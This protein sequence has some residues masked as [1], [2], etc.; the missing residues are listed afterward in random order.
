MVDIQQSNVMATSGGREY[1]CK[2]TPPSSRFLSSWQFQTLQNVVVAI[3]SLDAVNF[4]MP[5]L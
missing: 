3:L 2:D 4:E 1:R 5:Q